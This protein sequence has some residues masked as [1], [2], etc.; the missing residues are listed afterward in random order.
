MEK[1]Y[2]QIGDSSNNFSVKH[3]KKVT[4]NIKLNNHLWNPNYKKD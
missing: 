1:S 4:F 3:L 2:A